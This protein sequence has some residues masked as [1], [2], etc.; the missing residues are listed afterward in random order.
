MI[1]KY[2]EFLNEEVGLKNIAKIAKKYT[3]AEIFFHKD[4]DGIMSALSMRFFFKTYYNIET[5]DAHQIQYGGLEYAVKHAQPGNLPCLVDFAHSR[6]SYVIATDH[7]DKQAGAEKTDST[8]FKS[9]RSNAETI[10]GEISYGDVFTPGDIDLV[11]TVDS[12]DFLANGIKPEDV[13]NSIFSVNKELSAKKNRYMMGFVVNRLLLAYKNKRISV[14]SLDG[15][16]EHKNKNI[17]EC[18]VLDCN[19][20]LYSMFNNIKH[21]IKNATTNDKLGVLA[22]PETLAENLENYIQKMKGYKFIETETGDTIEY[23]P[24]N[25]RHVDMATSGK[26]IAKGSH[27]DEKYKIISQYGGGSMIKPGSYDRYVPFK[28]NP[29]ANFICIVWPMGLIQVSCN[30]FKEKK[31][32][33][34]NLGAIAK[35]VMSVH[36]KN[37]KRMFISLED[38]KRESE[39]TQELKAFKKQDGEDYTAVGFKYDDLVSFYGDCIYKGTG[40]NIRNISITDDKKLEEVININYESLTDDNKKFLKDYRINV[41]E[42]I[43]R[44][45]GGHP[46]ITNL[47]GFGNLKYAKFMLNKY[48]QTEKYTDLMKKI[49]REFINLLKVK[50][51]EIETNG[52]TEYKEV[53]VQFKGNDTGE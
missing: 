17:L 22:T 33:D 4:L 50:I 19:P 14:T 10:S 38:V 37:F 20:S 18:M 45:S 32:K 11:K 9:A 25:K 5:V 34:I 43:V 41:W 42:L 44:N 47:S 1:K 31:L 46:S 12:A 7:H 48:Y 6:P 8:Y 21:Y 30:P 29:E 24:K 13:Q 28:N 3:K 51:D 26:K 23:D 36:E 53:D 15:K 16:N 27:F 39:N 2:T 35:E 52:K 49:A 40:A